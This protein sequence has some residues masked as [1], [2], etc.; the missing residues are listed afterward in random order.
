MLQIYYFKFPSD[1]EAVTIDVEAAT[2]DAHTESNICVF[3]S[4]QRNL[5]SLINLH[6]SQYSSSLQ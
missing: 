5:V 3:V 4:V 6:T 2:V 1:V